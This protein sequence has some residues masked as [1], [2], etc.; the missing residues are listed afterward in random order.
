MIDDRQQYLDL[1]DFG[2]ERSRYEQHRDRMAKN[3]ASISAAGR[4]IGEMPPVADPER[5]EA[6]RRDLRLFCETY[7]QDIFYLPWS[8]IQLETIKRLQ[9][10]AMQGGKFAI[11]M[12]R[13]TGKSTLCERTAIWAI[14][15]GYRRYVCVIGGSD[16]AT[17]EVF[18]AIK[19][20]FETNETF[21][22]DF[23]EVCHA[24]AALENITNRC[25]G[26]TYLGARTHI[27]WSD[28]KLVMPIIGDSP[29]GGS[30]ISS[31]SMTGRIRGMKHQ[32]PD[33]E[34][35][36][37]DFVLVD[38]PQTRESA[39][40]VSQVKYRKD[41]INSDILGLAGP[42][43]T[44]TAVIPCTVIYPEDLA[45]QL[46]C[47]ETNPDWGGLRFSLLNGMPKNMHLWQRYWEIR[48]EC[49]RKDKDVAEATRFY[50]QNRKEMDDGCKAT[51][52]ERFN[53]GE[54]SGI[55]YGMNIYFSNPDGFFSEYQNQPYATE[56]G[57]GEQISAEKVLDRRVQRPPLEIP[58]AATRITMAVDVQKNVLYWALMAFDDK[59]SGWLLD[60][61]VWPE[62]SKQVFTTRDASP[63]YKE[64]FPGSGQ[65][66]ALNL[67]LGELLPPYLNRLYLREDG[68]ELPL[69]RCLIDSGWGESTD[70]IYNFIRENRLNNVLPSKGV[71]ITAT[72]KPFSE[73]QRRP[74]EIISPYEWR[75]APIRTKKHIRLLSYD[76]NYWKSFFR[77]RVFTAPGD[78]GAF[79]INAPRI[80][81]RLRLL[82]DQLSSEYSITEA[83]QGRRVDVWKLTPV[84]ENHW[85]DCVIGCMV[86]ASEQGAELVIPP[87]TAAGKE[88]R[89]ADKN[90]PSAKRKTYSIGKVYSYA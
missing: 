30:V 2:Q 67:A 74:G 77:N 53:A 68:A 31:T 50:A 83:A 54:I 81:D 86:A 40:S 25:R 73:Y 46:L 9:A 58:Q 59:F 71:G 12:P 63:T 45:D 90:R 52:P 5:R 80:D 48:S 15:Y 61:G 57:E 18:R 37:P 14:V 79:A 62:Q 27:E 32:V 42:G 10:A 76:T 39:R 7:F 56:L 88:A 43:K 70:T 33:G 84:K 75:I 35:L 66:G 82:A 44:I 78:P 16:P 85:L 38:D 8:P 47:R 55:Q 49:Q 13:G 23:P 34:V 65:E 29:I 24:V 17:R 1:G 6:C 51:W 19:N 64:A 87:S 3:Q 41:L 69:G 60:Y 21:M 22:A 11:A 28:V 89:R 36:R 20:S 26:Q 4:D 72:N